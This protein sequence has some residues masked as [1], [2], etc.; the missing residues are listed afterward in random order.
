MK[1]R[2]Q[3][4]LIIQLDCEGEEEDEEKNV[5]EKGALIKSKNKLSTCVNYTNKRNK[6]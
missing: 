5:V 4:G 3:N 6:M 1:E 2:G